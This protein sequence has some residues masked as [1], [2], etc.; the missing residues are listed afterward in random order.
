MLLSRHIKQKIC[1]LKMP[2]DFKT[3]EVKKDTNMILQRI[4]CSEEEH[5]RLKQ[6]CDDNDIIF[7]STPFD[8]KSADYLE[9]MGMYIWKIASCDCVNYP[10]VEH[11]ASK[12]ALFVFLLRHLILKK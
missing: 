2:Q 10:F 6:M 12:G 4:R 7:M 11:V 9:D 1:V 8:N 3:G 5:I